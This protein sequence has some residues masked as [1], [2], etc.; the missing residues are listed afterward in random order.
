MSDN[1]KKVLIL[2]DKLG[3]YLENNNL[4]IYTID[5]ESEEYVKIKD[6]E[7]VLSDEHTRYYF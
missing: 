3:E 4:D 7:Y 1:L 6:V 5:R 2:E